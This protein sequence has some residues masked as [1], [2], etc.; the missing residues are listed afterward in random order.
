MDKI[1]GRIIV[2]ISPYGKKYL[3]LRRR[4]N[5]DELCLEETPQGIADKVKHRQERAAARDSLSSLN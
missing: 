4:W 2:D 5:R 3:I 1:N